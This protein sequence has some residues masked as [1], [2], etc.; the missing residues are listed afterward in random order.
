M[1][2]NIPVGSSLARK[3]F[4]V[5]LFAR[6]IQAPQLTKT[7]TG[8]MPKQKQA[9]SK[10]K[11]QTS[12]DMPI[13]RA[14]DL[15]KSEGDSVSVDCF[16]TITGKPL[17]GDVDAEG[18][19]SKLSYSSMDI[20][21][22]LST[23][24]VDAGGK[25]ANQRTIHNLRGICMAQLGGYFP[26]LK[27]QTAL[28]HAAGAR[29]SMTGRDWVVPTES[30]PDFTS[31]MVNDIKAPTY[32]R[33]L[34]VDGTSFVQGGQQLGSIE[35]DDVWTLA[36]IDELSLML[37]DLDIPVQ[38]VKI[39]DD[40]AA[41]DEPIKGILNLSPRQ[42]NQIKTDST[43]NQNWR[44]FLQNAWNRKSYGSKHPLFSGE[45]GLWNGILVRVLP[46]Y[47]IRFN[48]GDVTKI[49][50]SASRYNANETE[51]TVNGSLTAGYSVERAILWG[52]QA[53]G[54]VYGKNQSSEYH[55]SWHE[56]KYNFDRNLEVA[57]DCMGGMSKI[58]F[59]FD[60]G[61]GNKEPTDNGVFV[62]DSAVKVG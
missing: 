5:G 52:A 22:D 55:F 2:S 18:K 7:L 19:G 25:M 15:S 14:T 45:P 59:N 34:V 32:N 23:K 35:S 50:S 40:P 48:G 20:R 3:F 1:Q 30:D 57:G 39:A 41:E 12:Y 56:R 26:R 4:G 36:H 10:L 61:Q 13:V 27:T 6:V 44:S 47:T 17:M 53:L 29:G 28:V 33:H 43:S 60:D 24:V 51:Q 37:D 62:I 46:R 38:P 31:I 16:D 42:W 9:E 21:I 58:R 54:D 11:G 8:P 49:V